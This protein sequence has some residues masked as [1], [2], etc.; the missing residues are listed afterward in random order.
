MLV[1][2]AVQVVPFVSLAVMS[3]YH[4]EHPLWVVLCRSCP[5][6]VLVKSDAYDW[7]GRMQMGGQVRAITHQSLIDCD[8]QFWVE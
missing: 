7:S 1:N 5:R 3:A 8:R 4:S 6:I 2:V